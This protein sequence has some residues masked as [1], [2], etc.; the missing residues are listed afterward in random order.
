MLC[1]DH[2][3]EKSFGANFGGQIVLLFWLEKWFVG[4]LVYSYLLFRWREKTVLYQCSF[5]DEILRNIHKPCH[6]L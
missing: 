3:D 4:W 6:A 2:E 1:F 5:N